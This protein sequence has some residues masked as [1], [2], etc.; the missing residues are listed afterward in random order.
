MQKVIFML[1][2]SPYGSE[3]VLTALRLALALADNENKPDLHLFL[4]S[5]AVVTAKAGQS[6][7]SGATL[8]DM[9]QDLL[10]SGAEIKVCKTCAVARGLA[11]SDLIAGIGIGT[12]PE[13][14]ALT[15]SADKLLTF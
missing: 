14:A 5:D 3:R 15:L 6:V 11:E 2:A 1:N 7:A 8:G 4:L 10:A 13:L 9:L 12:M